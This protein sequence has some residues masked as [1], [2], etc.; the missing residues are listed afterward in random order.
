LTTAIFEP[1]KQAEKPP[2]YLFIGHKIF[3]YD[4][5]Y[6]TVQIS[7]FTFDKFKVNSHRNP[8]RCNSVSK[9]YFI[10]DSVQ[11]LHVQQTFTYAK[12][13]ATSAVLGS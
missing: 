1:V 12:P 6:R 7:E 5:N 13:E 3:P 8:T 4:T 10:F 2:V 9:F 11:Q